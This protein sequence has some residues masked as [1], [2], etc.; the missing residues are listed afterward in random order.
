MPHALWNG[1]PHPM[2]RFAVMYRSMYRLQV[3]YTNDRRSIIVTTK[4]TAPG[5]ARTGGGWG[6]AGCGLQRKVAL[7]I[8]AC[9]FVCACMHVC[10]YACACVLMSPAAGSGGNTVC[11]RKGRTCE[12]GCRTFAFHLASSFLPFLPPLQRRLGCP[13]TRSC[14][15]TWSCTGEYGC[16]WC[17]RWCDSAGAWVAG[18]KAISS[19]QLWLGH[20]LWARRPHHPCTS[21]FTFACTLLSR[22]LPVDRRVLLI[23]PQG[24][25]RGRHPQPG[26]AAAAR[27]RP[28]HLPH[29][30][31]L[32]AHQ[33]CVQVGAAAGASISISTLL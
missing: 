22:V 31:L 4:P 6:W 24:V 7:C 1:V 8:G 9:M 10:A 15:T 20:I 3:K 19:L 14:W 28:P 27:P 23:V 13:L 29:R 30:L 11:E 2:Y 17:S 26:H 12:P 16:W 33:V 21:S 5:G 18:V 32:P 25:H